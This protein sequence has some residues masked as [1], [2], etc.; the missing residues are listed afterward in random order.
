MKP[1][2]KLTEGQIREVYARL[3]LESSG[4]RQHLLRQLGVVATPSQ[5][6]SVVVYET[7][8][9]CSSKSAENDQ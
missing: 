6:G 3:G 5:T 4:E 7:R 8:L 2:E 1:V 9:G